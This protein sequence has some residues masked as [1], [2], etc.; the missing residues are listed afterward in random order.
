M[1]K[2]YAPNASQHIS[3]ENKARELL[4]GKKREILLHLT[5]IFVQKIY[6]LKI[7]NVVFEAIKTIQFIFVR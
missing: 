5:G 7:Q 1:S 4:H 3:T 2:I 6:V